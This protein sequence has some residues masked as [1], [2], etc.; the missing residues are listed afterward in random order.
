MPECGPQSDGR[1]G[2]TSPASVTILIA[3][4]VPSA[5]QLPCVARLPAG[6]HYDGHS[7]Q[8][9]S[10]RLWLDSTL[11]GIKAVQVDLKPAC[12]VSGAVRV[13]T[14][15][16][17][18]IGLQRFDAPE[19]LRPLRAV[20]FYRFPGGCIV[21]RYRFAPGAPST[22]QFQADEALSFLSRDSVV[23]AVESVGFDL[24]GVGVRCQG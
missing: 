8:S 15:A 17:D 22:L 24:C 20:R 23:R 16:Q 4:A 6:W 19:D 1:P 9:G 5:T 21:Y 7:I 3:Q 14:S 11:A 12:D 13:P 18:E 10:A 2:A